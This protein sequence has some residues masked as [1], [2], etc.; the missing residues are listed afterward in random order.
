VLRDGAGPRVPR[1]VASCE[2]CL[3]WGLSYSQGV[4]LAC[5]NFAAYNKGAGDCRACGRRQLLK[6]GYCRLCWCQAYLERTS[7]PG[8]PLASWAAKVRHHQLFFAA[9]TPGAS[10]TIAPPRQ[11]PRRVGAKGRPLKAPPPPASRPSVEGIQGRLFD[12]GPRRYT[13]GK[14]DLR[15][16]PAPDN[17]WLAW[18]LHLAH[19]M[20][21]SRGFNPAV[22]R[23]LQR[24]LVMLLSDYRPDELIR[25]S[26]Y[27][28]V[29]RQRGA[30][31]AHTSEVLAQ[32]G[33]LDD[34]RPATFAAWLGSKLEGLPAGMAAETRGWATTLKEGGSRTR[35][36]TE[37]T[38]R[39]YMGVVRPVLLEWSERYDHLREVT[40]DD[41]VTYT[42][43]LEGA[44]RQLTLSGLRSMFGWAKK[45]GVVFANPAARVR[46]GRVP[47]QLWQPLQA[48]DITKAVQAAVTPHARVYVVLAAVHAAR[49]G[50]IRTMT[51]DDV[52]LA[53]RRLTIAGH[54]R[55][56]DDL[57]FQILS[58]WLDYRRSRWPNTANRHLLISRESALGLGPVSEVWVSHSLR[59]LEASIERLRI[60]RQLEEAMAS[61]ADPLHLARVFNISE[62]T[63]VRYAENA[64]QLLQ[65]PHE[66]FSSS[67]TQVPNGHS[68]R[69]DHLGSP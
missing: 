45:N 10:R 39:I 32:M 66:P 12:P 53:N 11:L 35:P 19:Q 14:L 29:L 49:L 37:Q 33:I 43:R 31:V 26:D 17:P 7:G 40:R 63:A 56:L 24:N 27:E 42:D 68:A 20:S 54:A 67:P 41:V 61:R 2:S 16:G 23:A 44:E 9:M 47:R 64:R 13:P 50:A 51:L 36:R 4:C 46:A 65:R 22:H 52:D 28:G 34:D 48:E 62:T 21:E 18:A 59:G 25:R 69:P 8:T 1:R 30:S 60:D 38:V 58:E 57:S 3:A 5:Y 15:S 6:K 55:P